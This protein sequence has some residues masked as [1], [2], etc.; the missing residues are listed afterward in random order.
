LRPETITVYIR[1]AL[2]GMHRAL[3]RF[4]D[5]T[6]NRRPH[7]DTTNSGAV[8]ITHACA[9]SRYWIEDVGLGRHVDRDRPSE[10]TVRSTVS[11]LHALLDATAERLDALVAE[12]ET[13]PSALDHELRGRLWGGDRS[14]AS[15]VLHA[16]EELFQ[17]LGH[18]ELTADA[19]GTPGV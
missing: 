3:D 13:G 9:S 2:A 19:L 7:G 16:L 5:D 12:L 1:Q 10:F 11:E 8:L 18:L 4:D 6:V 14:D 15:L 17:H